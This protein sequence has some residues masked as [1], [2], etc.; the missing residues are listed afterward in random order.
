SARVGANRGSTPA[1]RRAWRAGVYALIAAK[2]S[3]PQGELTVERM[4]TLA[5]VNRTS[6][7]RRWAA[8]APREE[9]TALR[10][11][12]QRAALIN[13]RYGYRRI[14]AQLSRDGVVVYHK[15]AL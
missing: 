1:E 9:E 3:R 5:Q 8:S 12:V 14:A 7:Y 15:R 2:T 6:Y 10:D 13:R 11:A 4:C